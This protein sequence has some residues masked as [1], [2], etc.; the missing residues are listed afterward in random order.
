M[1]PE[2]AQKNDYEGSKADIFSLGVTLFALANGIF[3]FSSSLPSDPFY[4]FLV[5]RDYLAYW[6]EVEMN[7]T[8]KEF[9]DL[10]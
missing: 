9:K 5:E 7:E 6:Q 8:S 2:I 1:A 10:F 4:K 3:P